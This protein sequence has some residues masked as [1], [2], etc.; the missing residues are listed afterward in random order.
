MGEKDENLKNDGAAKEKVSTGRLICIVAI[1]VILLLLGIFAIVKFTG[2]KYT[3]TY[4]PSGSGSPANSRITYVAKDENT[5]ADE[6]NP[7]GGEQ[8]GSENGNQEGNSGGSA[9][10]E[11]A[12]GSAQTPTAGLSQRLCK[13]P[14]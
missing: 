7:N 10:N 5:G 12:S 1:V 13:P 11:G 14:N 9:S 6:S 3:N 2:G 8:Q 4:T